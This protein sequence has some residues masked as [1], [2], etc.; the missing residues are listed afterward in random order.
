[1]LGREQPQ[2]QVLG[3]V[4]VLIFIDKDEAEA[5]LVG[6]QNGPVGLKQRQIVQ[7][8]I[9]EVTGVQF[10]QAF[11]IGRVDPVEPPFTEALGNLVQRHF[12]RHPA[13]VFPAA[14]CVGD[15]ARAMRLRID[16]VV[17][18][19]GL[20]QPKLIIVIEDG[21]VL[22]EAVDTK[23]TGVDAQ[24]ARGQTVESTQP[25]AGR[26]LADQRFH[27]LAHFTRCLVGEG[28]GQHFLRP[29]GAGHQQM[30]DPGRQGAGLARTSTRQHQHRPHQ[31]LDRFPL[32]RVQPLQVGR[33]K[34]RGGWGGP[35]QRRAFFIEIEQ[36][37]CH[38]TN[39]EH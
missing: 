5:V 4:G 22:I 35:A 26:R 13:P 17:D 6:F 1:M 19:Q 32:R 38:G 23:G 7:Q 9:A 10:H 3:D 11:L 36:I 39:V 28:H 24:D 12:L 21:E 29:G 27:P 14:D 37:L 25:P 34:G 2:P 8:Q 33:F 31:R 30:R 15:R 20:E 16:I 18:Q